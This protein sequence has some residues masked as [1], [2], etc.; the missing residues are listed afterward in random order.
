MNATA[1]DRDVAPDARGLRVA[2]TLRGGLHVESVGAGPP[3]ALLHGWAMHGG[4]FGPLAARL[5]DR[6]RVHAVDLPGHGHSPPPEAVSIESVV[7]AVGAA[8]DAPEVADIAADAADP[9]HASGGTGIPVCDADRSR[10]RAPVTLIGWSL[11]AAI[12]LAF[13]RAR[14][15]RV[16]RLVLVGATPR[17]VTD[18]DWPHAM[19]AEALARF[20]DEL[21]VSWR[22][23]LQ[24]FLALQVHGSDHGRAAL[25]ALHHELFARGQPAPAVLRDGLALLGRLDLRA[26]VPAIATP[27]LVVAGGRDALTPPGAARWLAAALPDARLVE[28]TGAAHVPFLSHPDEFH[29]AV[30]GFLDGR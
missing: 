12:A 20:G 9:A 28:I 8:L 27:T 24:R 25:H 11:G 26:Q 18:V 16:A 15:D 30:D 13:A 14:P 7:A 5:A 1:T 10:V 23:T 21:A 19:T 17:F 22:H 29:A 4:L 3:V 2:P 6:H